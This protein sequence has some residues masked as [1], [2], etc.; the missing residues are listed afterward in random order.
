M[1]RFDLA[2]SPARTI[3]WAWEN[4]F[5]NDKFIKEIADASNEQALA[6]A[7]VS[8]GIEK[9]S[10][11]VQ[12]NAATAEESAASSEKLNSEAQM[13]SDLIGTFKL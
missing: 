13:L 2:A 9:I 5:C 1:L 11:V 7:D 6:I 3:V 4:L 8:E 10:M 12:S